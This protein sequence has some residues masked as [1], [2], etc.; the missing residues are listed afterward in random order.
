MNYTE[1]E[2]KLIKRKSYE[3]GVLHGVTFAL[4]IYLL[5]VIVLL[6]TY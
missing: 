4:V 6:I 1:K 3:K 2:I 5:A